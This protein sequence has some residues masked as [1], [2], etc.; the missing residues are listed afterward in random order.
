MKRRIIKIVAIVCAVLTLAAGIVVVRVNVASPITYCGESEEDGPWAGCDKNR[1]DVDGPVERLL[2]KGVSQIILVDMAVGGPR[3]YKSHNVLQLA[4]MAMT[5]WKERTEK[6][7]RSI[8]TVPGK[9]GVI[10]AVHG[11]F[12]EYKPQYVWDAVVQIFSHDPNHFLHR[13]VVWNSWMWGRILS[14]SSSIKHAL[15]YDFQYNRIGG[16]DPFKSITQKQLGSMKTELDGLGGG[17]GLVFEVEWAGWISP[18]D[19]AHYMFPRFMLDPTSKKDGTETPVPLIWVNDNKNL[20]GRSYPTAPQGWTYS[21]G[22]PEEDPHVA[23]D[24]CPNPITSDPELADIHV[25]GIA[26][27]MSAGVSTDKTGIL[28]LNHAL[29]DNA[30][31]FDPKIDDTV[32]LNRRIK[33]ALL[34]QYPELKPEHIIGGFMGIYVKN[35]ENGK[36]E[37]TRDMRGENQ[38]WA[39]LYESKKQL[40]GDE[41]GYRYWDGLAY[42]MQ[43][44][45]EHIVIGFPQIVT[46]SVLNLVEVHNVIATE[47]GFKTWLYHNKPDTGTYPD[48]G[49]PFADYWGIWVRTECD[50]KPCCFD[51]GGCG[52]KG[53]Y[54][55]KRQAKETKK[56]DS[57]DPSLAY[58]VSAFGHLG[59]NPNLGAPNDDQA[60]QTQYRGTWALYR[61]P[62]D[63][64]R[65][66]RLLAEHVLQ[67]VDASG[68]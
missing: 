35:K 7:S 1:Y 17:N 38:G 62:N 13:F 66:G 67:A 46:D 27:G 6:D 14:S 25:D 37:P 34:G 64:P 12:S 31:F 42:L 8:E 43:Q 21:Q 40:P 33:A 61:P 11:G 19:P 23:L 10:Y 50:G 56:M 41:W 65:L 49:H 24:C 51:M 57:R 4:K 29:R 9:I 47:V 59:Y 22:L 36:L 2:D 52:D 55:P 16:L 53:S 54:P 3:F 60:V 32:D 63:D 5:A 58:D 48:V 68:Q 15:S 26:K 18:D 30:E 20:M 45:V 28:L 39:W 44:G